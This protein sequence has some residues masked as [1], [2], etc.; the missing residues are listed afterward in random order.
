M[1][2]RTTCGRVV[3]KQAQVVKEFLVTKQLHSFHNGLRTP[4]YRVC[5]LCKQ[6]LVHF[7]DGSYQHVLEHKGYSTLRPLWKQLQLT[8]HINSL[9]SR[10][11]RYTRQMLRWQALSL[12]YR[13]W[14]C[15]PWPWEWGCSSLL[16]PSPPPPPATGGRRHECQ[17]CRGLGLTPFP[18]GAVS[19]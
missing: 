9:H 15:K 11:T 8:M 7:K 6:P 14:G 18:S 3:W 10:C 19:V 5:F 13:H 4:S 17:G 2:I 16:L 12:T 1:G